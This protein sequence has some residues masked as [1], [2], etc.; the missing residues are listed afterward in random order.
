[1]IPIKWVEPIAELVYKIIKL[2]LQLCDFILFNKYNFLHWNI[3]VTLSFIASCFL[4]ECW[5]CLQI[6][7]TLILSPIYGVEMQK[8]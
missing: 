4:V 7:K 3:Y 2:I 1:M 5:L 6:T 8:L